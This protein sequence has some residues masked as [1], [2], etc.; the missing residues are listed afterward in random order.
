[1][2]NNSVNKVTSTP[3]HLILSPTDN[4]KILNFLD[5][6]SIGSNS[7]DSATA[8]KKIQSFSKTNP[9]EL[10]N[11][12][13][14]FNL[15]YNKL[16]NLYKSDTDLLNS[17]SY[18]T[19]R[20][21]NFNSKSSLT[22]QFTTNL[23]EK[24]VDKLISY[25]YNLASSVSNPA[26][27]LESSKSSVESSNLSNL[28]NSF[29]SM[30]NSSV[31]YDLGKLV[32]YPSITSVINQFTDSKS[33]KNPFKYALGDDLN[34]QTVLGSD[35]LLNNFSNGEIQNFSTNLNNSNKALNNN[36]S[37]SFTDV[38]SA[39]QQLLASDRNPRLAFNLFKSNF[40]LDD[41]NTNTSQ[42]VNNDLGLNMLNKQETL[43]NLSNL[44]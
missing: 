24:S 36:L 17:T 42:L 12:S 4:N 1:M 10:F 20:Q 22:N 41:Y 40:N 8:F 28:N 29:N 15:K 2:N 3:S 43:F 32:N 25:N 30:L 44:N 9:Q 23:D 19:F 39:G 35:L 6:N 16:S 26:L 37:Y 18:G 13:S 38:K 14:E 31:N 33:F 5:F 27:K 11:T 21:H 34:K 7:L